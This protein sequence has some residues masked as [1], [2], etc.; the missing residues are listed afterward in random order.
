MFAKTFTLVN[1]CDW[2]WREFVALAVLPDWPRH[3]KPSFIRGFHA[4]I[5]GIGKGLRLSPFRFGDLSVS[6]LVDY[7]FVP[8][9]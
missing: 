7:L 4:L 2:C 3:L 5:Q 9:G 8:I 1:L 6:L